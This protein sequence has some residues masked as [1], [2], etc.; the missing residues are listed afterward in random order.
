MTVLRPGDVFRA[1]DLTPP[2]GDTL[3]LPDAL[4][5]S[6]GIVVFYTTMRD[7]VAGRRGGKQPASV[8]CSATQDNRWPEPILRPTYAGRRGDCETGAGV[9]EMERCW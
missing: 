7:C 2:G 9:F 1:G 8:H 6:F 4:Q 3:A 5:G